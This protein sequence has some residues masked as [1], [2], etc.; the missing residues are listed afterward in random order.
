MDEEEEEA[1]SCR[2]DEAIDDDDKMC[3]DV[4]LGL[5]KETEGLK[6]RLREEEERLM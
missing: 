3:L 1:W 5:K 4:R 2:T 6:I